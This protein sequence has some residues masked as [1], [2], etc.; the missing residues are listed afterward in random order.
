[1][2]SQA[3]R[4]DEKNNRKKQSELGRYFTLT[5]SIDPKT[6]KLGNMEKIQNVK[7]NIVAASLRL[8]GHCY[9]SDPSMW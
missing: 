1:M 3:S 9:Q 2:L 5:G 4:R 6:G 7:N 8:W